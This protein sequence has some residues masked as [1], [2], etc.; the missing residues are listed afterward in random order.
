MFQFL[1]TT[2][3]NAP[4]NANWNTRYCLVC[5][6]NV[7]SLALQLRMFSDHT[8]PSFHS[9][10]CRFLW[11]PVQRVLKIRW[12]SVFPVMFYAVREKM[13]TLSSK[14]RFV[15]ILYNHSHCMIWEDYWIVRVVTASKKK[16]AISMVIFDV[17][18]LVWSCVQITVLD[19]TWTVFRRYSRFREM[20][21]SLKLKY[22]EVWLACVHRNNSDATSRTWL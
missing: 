6:G 5:L 15:C 21:K 8:F 9:G 22:P 12:R 11:I 2:I 17:W 1:R 14:S 18:D 7:I 13:N 4:I 3:K 16:N 20:H 19:E 10:W